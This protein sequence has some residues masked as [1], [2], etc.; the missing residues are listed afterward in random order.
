MWAIYDL[1]TNHSTKYTYA[2]SLNLS[3][4]DWHQH[5]HQPMTVLPLSAI[6]HL[7]HAQFC[8]IWWYYYYDCYYPTNVYCC[9]DIATYF[10]VHYCPSQV[11]I[12][13]CYFR[14][15]QSHP[16]WRSCLS[17]ELALE[18]DADSDGQHFD[19]P[20]W[21]VASDD[22]PV[23]S[24]CNFVSVDASWSSVFWQ[25]YSS[26]STSWTLNLD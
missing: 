3:S 22:D 5:T 10:V 17:G 13:T 20:W 1:I 12:L 7:F 26:S 4:S 8:S 25:C 11:Q 2:N 19:E 9:R 18:L 24:L 23:A 21:G 6:C 14:L 16:H 15:R